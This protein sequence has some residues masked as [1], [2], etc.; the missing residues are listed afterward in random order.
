MKKY[1][2]ATLFLAT[3][4]L[5]GSIYNVGDYVSETHQNVSYPVCYGEYPSDDFSLADLNGE[6]NGG[7]W[8]V[9]VIDMSATWCGP[10]FTFIPEF[11]EI[12]EGWEDDEHVFGF[13]SLMD[14][15]QPYTC[16]QWGNFGIQ[17]VPMITN[18]GNGFGDHIFNFFNTG[19]AIP[20]TV[21][22]T[23]EMQVFFKANQVSVA[24]ANTKIQQM[25][26]ACAPCNNPDYDDDGVLNEFDNCQ[27]DYNPD[28]ED[29]D[30]DGV[31]DAC[32]DCHDMPGDV[33]DDVQIDILDIVTTVQIILNGGFNS[34]SHTD[35]EKSDADY[36]G[37]GVINVLDVIQ[38]INVIIGTTRLD[39]QDAGTAQ[40]VIQQTGNDMHVSLIANTDVAGVELGI[41]SDSEFGIQLKDNSHISVAAGYADGVTRL[42]AYSI[43]NQPFDSRTVEFMV[44]DGAQLNFDDLHILAGDQN[45]NALVL[46]R[47]ADDGSITT[48]PY[49]F[50]LKSVYPNPFNPSTEV[51]FVLPTEGFTRL[52]AFNLRGQVV[53]VI[54]EGYQSI[55][56]HTYTWHANQL[57][58]GVY[59]LRLE[60]NGQVETT[61]AVLLK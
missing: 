58:A 22:L 17:G 25:L 6:V 1:I 60:S 28:Q 21:F 44:M 5:L 19:N 45:G 10:C 4:F 52:A 61:K 42:V 37:D 16:T 29:G 24:L 32:D 9:T 2:I 59:Y 54:H 23:H 47:S 40:V 35:C 57:P 13:V 3:S 53:D 38:I 8:T 33:N 55:G 26:D 11:D 7:Q 34:P 18:D 48:G 30:N 39:N 51:T 56:T 12:V 43:L 41:L 27:D 15:N 36:S 20:S 49:S 31:G 50:E 46:T 14:M